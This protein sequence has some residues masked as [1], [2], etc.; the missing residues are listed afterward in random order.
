MG[1]SGRSCSPNAERE[2]DSKES[3]YCLECFKCSALHLADPHWDWYCLQ[4]VWVHKVALSYHSNVSSFTC[5]HS[6]NFS[7]LLIPFSISFFVLLSYPPPSYYYLMPC[8]R[9]VFQSNWTITS[10]HRS[11]TLHLVEIYVEHGDEYRV[12]HGTKKWQYSKL[13]LTSL[14]MGG[15]KFRFR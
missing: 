2:W 4:S 14:E 3:S 5:S 8:T 1:S 15:W 13:N 7:Q 9:Y 12:C 10:Q 11:D 6:C